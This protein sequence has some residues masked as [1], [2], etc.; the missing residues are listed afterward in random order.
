MIRLGSCLPSLF[1]VLLAAV[2]GGCSTG[3][4]TDTPRPIPGTSGAP[5]EVNIIARDYRFDPNPIDLT[6][7]ETIL[8]HLINGGLEVHDVVLGDESVQAAWEAVEGGAHM[9]APPGST[10]AAN[11][12]LRS[13]LRI[14][15]RS[16]E[17]ADVRW[18]VPAA[19]SPLVVGCHIRDHWARGM[20][21]AV[22][23]LVPGS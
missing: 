5:R 18:T 10:P 16:G 8:L 6:P 14:V 21:A 13:G 23:A 15:L 19:A 17:R 7:G 4:S 1:R 2:L 9:D 20:Q 11:A 22:R 3:A 12:V